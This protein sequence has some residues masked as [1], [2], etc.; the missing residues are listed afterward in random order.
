MSD[1]QELKSKW[2]KNPNFKKEYEK[3]DL[4]WEIKKYG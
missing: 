4:F 3:F 1:L 2:M